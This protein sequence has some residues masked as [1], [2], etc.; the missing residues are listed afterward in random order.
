MDA[1]QVI[2]AEARYLVP[3]YPRPPFV[4]TRG[5]GVYLYDSEGR[6]Y[7]DW[8]AGIAVNAL[9]YGDPEIV[10]TL[11][12]AAAGLIHV[13][14]LY[15]TAPHVAL[16]EALVQHSF[17]DR[18]YFANSGTEAVEAAIKFSRKWARTH[19]G[20]GKTQI[21]AFTGSFHGRT[22]GALAL[23][24]REK[25][26]AP[27][28]PLMPDVVFARFNDLASAEAAIGPRTAAVIV[29]PVQG[30]GGIHP[31]D[32]AFLQ[33]LRELCDRHGAALIFDEIQCGLGRT[34]T[35]WA[36][37]PSG[38]RP[39][40][41]TLAKP[42]GGGLPI[43]ATLVTEAIA[44]VIGPGDHGSTFAAGPLVTA[45][46]LRVFQRIADPAF[47]ASVREKGEALVRRLREAQLPHVVEVR[48][49][50]LMLGLELTVSAKKVVER[51]YEAGLLLVNA[52]DTV[53]RLIPPLIIG[54]E[55]VDELLEK[56]PRI[57]EEASG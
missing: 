47:L 55:Q 4:L 28:R 48:G 24:A 34:G 3:T 56:L 8:V 19:F 27:F 39:D 57:L 37:E 22:M 7:T 5:E 54:Q 15:H 33:G 18:V 6:R 31:A 25:Y 36:H 32:D 52:G 51:G 35:L 17:A 40:L 26:Q 10:A 41:M 29:E 1:R 43:G 23:T 38:V 49:R 9:G 42:L 2:E 21:V 16:A 46:A 20:P 45:V 13:S 11:Q 53:L 30:E 12:E 14:N 44:E 50:G